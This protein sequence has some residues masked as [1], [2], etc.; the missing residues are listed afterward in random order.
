MKQAATA[1]SKLKE[2]FSEFGV[3]I[4]RPDESGFDASDYAVDY[5]LSLIPSAVRYLLD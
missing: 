3:D 4:S 1:L 5:F 2:F